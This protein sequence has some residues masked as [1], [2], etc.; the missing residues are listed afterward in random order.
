MQV[1][2]AFSIAIRAQSDILLLDE[3]LAVGD[4]AFQQKC[5][6]Y[7]YKLKEAKQTVVLVTH[8]MGA[9]KQFCSR[10][11]L[12]DK[13]KLKMVGEPDQASLEYEKLNFSRNGEINKN[14]I[15]TIRIKNQKGDPVK[16][17][18]YGEKITFSMKI[19][20]GQ[21]ISIAGFVLQKNGEEIFATNTI[22]REVNFNSGEVSLCLDAKIGNGTYKVIGGLFGDT[23][24]DV[25]GF[26][27]GPN[28]TVHGQPIHGRAGE[29]WHGVS[30]IE[31]EWA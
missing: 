28:F 15:A 14:Q 25:K 22:G 10:A 18:R 27:E 8:D 2:L 9:I 5:Y 29:E 16:N 7:F 31:N 24:Y 6:E 3:V 30:Y 19:P 26:I 4:A 13:G 11:I 17:F 20:K 12:V 1:R 21:N 23:R